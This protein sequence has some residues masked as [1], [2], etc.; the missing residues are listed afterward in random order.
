MFCGGAGVARGVQGKQEG[1][2]VW[3]VVDGRALE[4]CWCG[5]RSESKSESERVKEDVGEQ[6]LDAP[7]FGH[8][9]VKRIVYR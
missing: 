5:G 6:E 9:V 2:V 8:E 4:G 3:S 1:W 7:A